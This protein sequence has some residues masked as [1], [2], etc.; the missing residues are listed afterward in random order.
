MEPQTKVT[1]K[2]NRVTGVRKVVSERIFEG[3]TP[4]S[5][6][7]PE[8]IGRLSKQE[9]EEK[10]IAHSKFQQWQ[11]SEARKDEIWLQIL[12]GRK[13]LQNIILTRKHVGNRVIAPNKEEVSIFIKGANAVNRII[14]SIFEH[15]STPYS[16]IQQMQLCQ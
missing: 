13:E 3:Y 7:Q 16:Q 5:A 9:V 10:Y 15:T 11:K 6:Y 12:E 2:G 14:N 8:H 4:E 1:F